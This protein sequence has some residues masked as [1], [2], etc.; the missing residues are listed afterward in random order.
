M[1]V[2][3]NSSQCVRPDFVENPDSNQVPEN[4]EPTQAAPNQQGEQISQSRK[5][6]MDQSA[7]MKA[8]ELQKVNENQGTKSEGAQKVEAEM[9]KTRANG[10]SMRD[11][12]V[13][14]AKADEGSIHAGA[15]SIA[16][17][18]DRMKEVFK[19]SAGI[20]LEKNQKYDRSGQPILQ[21]KDGKG[22]RIM[23][24]CLGNRYLEA[25][26]LRLQMGNWKTNRQQGERTT[27]SGYRRS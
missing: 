2:T 7:K 12:V 11:V 13:A 20:Q 24:R 8:A 19:N 4:Q 10:G 22:S 9:D 26:R 6:E 5:S 18:E 17:G 23:V 27:T 25:S 15:H 14:G 21:L 3:T 16:K 1:K